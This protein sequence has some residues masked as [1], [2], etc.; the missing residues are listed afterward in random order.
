MLNDP[1][2]EKVIG[3]AIAVHSHFGPGLFESTYEQALA[4]QLSCAGLP[5]Q[6]QVPIGASYKGHPLGQ[7]FRADIAVENRLILAIKSTERILPVHE[8]QILTYLRLG[9][10]PFGLLLNFNVLR[11]K[12]G[13]R[14]YAM[15]DR[16]DALSHAA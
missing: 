4:I 9:H 11:L 8:A 2:T 10:Y 3:L 14:R 7:V 5:F 16:M 15:T 6:R 1:L 13:I 12:Q